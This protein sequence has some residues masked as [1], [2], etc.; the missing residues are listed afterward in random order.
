MKRILTLI[1]ITAILVALVG[2]V[3]DKSCCG[4]CK[5]EAEKCTEDAKC[6]SYDDGCKCEAAA[7]CTGWCPDT[8]TGVYK[9]QKVACKGECK[10]NPGGPPCEACVVK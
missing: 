6:A 1:A 3:C 10:A 9:G 5:C 8:G 7:D 2:C 4:G